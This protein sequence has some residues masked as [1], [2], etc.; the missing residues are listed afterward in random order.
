MSVK[1]DQKAIT[2]LHVPDIARVPGPESGVITHLGHLLE[3]HPDFQ[4]GARVAFTAQAG[5]RI[6]VDGEELYLITPMV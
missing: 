3:G 1:P 2:T 6:K 5:E 4:V